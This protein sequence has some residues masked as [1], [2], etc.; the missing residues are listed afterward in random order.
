MKMMQIDIE[1]M[2]KHPENM[3]EAYSIGCDLKIATWR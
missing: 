2:S 1:T 3:P